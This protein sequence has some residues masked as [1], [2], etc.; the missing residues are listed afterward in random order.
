LI[1]QERFNQWERRIS[2][3]EECVK[4][5]TFPI[6]SSDGRNFELFGTSLG[7]LISGKKYICTANH[8]I[9]E[10]SKTRAEV[11]IAVNGKFESLNLDNVITIKDETIDYDVCL[12]ELNDN[13]DHVPYLHQQEFHQDNHFDGSCQYLQGF[14]IS[15]NK[16]HDIHDHEKEIIK[17][18][19][20]KSVFRVEQNI[21]HP[22][23]GV[24]DKTHLLFKLE[25][26]VYKKEGSLLAIELKKH[27]NMPGL[28]GHSGCGIWNI[29]NTTTTLAGV[30]ILF[31]SGIGV[32]TKAK[33]ILELNNWEMIKY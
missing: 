21:E 5:Y 23:T 6:F 2:S 12:I 18:G 9:Q 32:G 33:C 28:K 3:V 13:P 26:S 27:Q 4:R 25:E 31:K 10:I 1:D 19:Y 7:V 15:Q 14:P 17:T 24:N 20:L 11:V 8:L 29:N 30:F 16:Y 22:F